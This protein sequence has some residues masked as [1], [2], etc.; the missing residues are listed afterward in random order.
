MQKECCRKSK[1][2]TGTDRELK[3]GVFLMRNLARIWGT[4]GTYSMKYYP[5][6]LQSQGIIEYLQKR[7][8]LASIKITPEMQ[9][10]GDSL[11]KRW[12]E[13]TTRYILTEFCKLWDLLTCIQARTSLR[14]RYDRPCRQIHRYAG[15]VHVRH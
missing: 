5:L 1:E 11:A 4:Q 13:L 12:R 6:L 10:R 15:F 7:L 14:E 3:I 8:N 9:E 2:W